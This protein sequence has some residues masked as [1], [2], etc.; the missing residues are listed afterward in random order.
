MDAMDPKTSSVLSAPPPLAAGHDPFGLLEQLGASLA[1][2]KVD[3]NLFVETTLLVSAA[4]GVASALYRTDIPALRRPAYALASQTVIAVGL[5]PFLRLM[6][7]CFFKWNVRRHEST[8]AGT[9]RGLTVNG[10]AHGSCAPGGTTD[11]PVSKRTSKAYSPISPQPT[12]RTELKDERELVY[13]P[14]GTSRTDARYVWGLPP[15]RF[16]RDARDQGLIPGLVMGPLLASACLLDAVSAERLQAAGHAPSAVG[17]WRLPLWPAGTELPAWARTPPPSPSDGMGYLSSARLALLSMHTLVFIINVTHIVAMHYAPARWISPGKTSHRTRNFL[18]FYGAVTFALAVAAHTGILGLLGVSVAGHGSTTASGGLSVWEVILVPVLYQTSLITTVALA[19]RN[20]TYGELVITVAY[21]VT[22]MVEATSVTIASITRSISPHTFRAPN[23]LLVLQLA[24]IVGTFSMGYLTSPLLYISRSLAQRP[25]HRLRWPEKRKGHRKILSA[26]F[27]TLAT[28]FIAAVLGPWTRWILHTNPWVWTLRFTLGLETHA[29]PPGS[30]GWR[31]W[32]ASP[33]ALLAWWAG[34]L[35][36][37]AIFW[38]TATP[39]VFVAAGPG[40][41]AGTYKSASLSSTFSFWPWTRGGSPSLSHF[42]TRSRSPFSSPSAP[43]HALPPEAGGMFS[44]P[45]HGAERGKWTEAG[46]PMSASGDA[47][48]VTMGLAGAGDKG[49][50]EAGTPG[51]LSTSNRSKRPAIWLSLNAKR[52]FFHVLAIVMFIPGLLL[53]VRPLPIAVLLERLTLCS[54]NLPISPRVS[55]L[56]SSLCA[57]IHATLRC[58]RSE[59]R[60][61]SSSPVS[62]TAKIRMARLYFHPSTSCRAAHS[63]SGSRPAPQLWLAP[64]RH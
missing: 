43:V 59:L 48:A 21:G 56:Q 28:I 62:W 54:R 3:T 40:S 52:K 38:A 63:R 44:Y 31:N 57:S 15:T 53:N 60:Y 12:T 41:A 20:F 58:T 19:R 42:G 23:A 25:T 5:D 49:K 46:A 33:L 30:L 1:L 13:R 39:G 29:S 2:Y 50:D 11:H 34:C 16:F 32:S 14:A 17:E 35:A 24:L 8:V 47:A 9:R 36:A 7:K 27:Y 10:R 45:E 26:S 64:H 6:D 61:M 55:P 4:L 37:T 22:I 51:P 18:V